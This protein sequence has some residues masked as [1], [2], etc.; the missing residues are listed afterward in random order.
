LILVYC[1][2]FLQTYSQ[3]NLLHHMWNS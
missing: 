3:A 1:I 2:G